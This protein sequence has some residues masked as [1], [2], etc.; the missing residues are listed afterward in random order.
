M[1]VLRAPS[2]TLDYIVSAGFADH[3]L[4]PSFAGRNSRVNWSAFQNGTR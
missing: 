2:A 3:K 1:S 4:A